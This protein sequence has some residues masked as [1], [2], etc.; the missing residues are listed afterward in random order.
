MNSFRLIL[1]TVVALFAIAAGGT[2]AVAQTTAPP[3]SI[4]ILNVS[5][6]PTREFYVAYNAL[7]AAYWKKKTGQDVTINQSHGGS[8]AQA[9]AV[10]EG[11]DADVVTLGVSSDIDA[12]AKKSGALPANWQTRLPDD[13]SPYTSTVVLVVRKGNP[14]HIRD[15]NDLIKP[16]VSVITANPKTGAGARW[17]FLAAYAYALRHNHN[18]DAKARAFVGALYKNVPVLDSGARGSTTTFVERGIGDVLIAWENEAYYVLRSPGGSAYQIV[19]PSTSILAQPPVAWLD[20]NDAKH[21]TQA[22]SQGY[23]HYLYSTSAQR[24]ACRYGYRPVETS[25]LGTCG[26]HFAR[27]DLTTIASFGGWALAQPKYF[28][29]GGVFDQLYQPK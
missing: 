14:K 15:W 12:I 19:T 6:D 28:G 9:R 29:D 22:V 21:G 8:G 24:L 7:F 20:V 25:V 16:D 27:S 4:S 10:I 13:S 3:A 5:Y 18:D 2:V 23:L 1:A 26:T 11:L 17:N